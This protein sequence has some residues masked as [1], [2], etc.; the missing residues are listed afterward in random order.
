MDK[1]V[2]EYANKLSGSL[3]KIS[4]LPALSAGI[5][6]DAA[7]A[8]ALEGCHALNAHRVGIWRI[9]TAA[10]AAAGAAQQ[11][12]KN[13]SYYDM[14]AGE[15]SIHHDFYL[16]NSAAYMELLRSE[17]LIVVSDFKSPNP[18]TDVYG[19]TTHNICAMLDAPIRIGGKLVGTV[20]IEQDFCDGFPGKRKWM[21][22][23]QN[24]ASSLADFMAIAIEASERR[25]L[26]QRTESMMS[27]LPGMV[28]QCLHDPPDF[29]YTFVSE[30][31][32]ALTGYSPQELLGKSAVKYF[33]M[34]HPDDVKKVAQHNEQTLS[35]GLPL[36]TVFRIV[37]KDGAIKWVWERS[38]IAEFNPDGTPRLL[39][40]FYTDIT[41]QR[42]IEAA[43]L[44][45][46]AKSAFLANMSHEIRTPMNA[47]L[48]M[49]ELALRNNPKPAVR[50]NLNNIKT[51]GGQLLSIINDILDFSKIEAGAIEICEEKYDVSSMI[52]DIV[53]MIHV[54]IGEKPIEFI[55]DD[56][57]ELPAEMIGDVTRIKQIAINLLSNA[58]K[59][60]RKGHIIFS[61]SAEK[62]SFDK[63]GDTYRLKMSV[64]DTGMGIRDEDIPLLF[65]NFTQLDTR[66]NRSVEG[67]GLGLA[68]VKSL[69]EL[70]D[71]EINVTSKYNEGSCFSF[72]IMQKAAGS[73]GNDG[74][75]LPPQNVCHV[76]IFC[77]NRK[78]ELFLRDKLKK[79]NVACDI[80]D[81]FRGLEK[82]SHV[83]FDYKWVFSIQQLVT[84][85]TRLIA[86]TKKFVDSERLPAKA[87]LVHTPLTSIVMFKL[88]EKNNSR[89]DADM[90][91]MGAGLT[92]H[93]ARF[94]I[95]DDIDI[96]LI[97]AEETLAFY[98]G[99][100]DSAS[101]G[102]E[103]VDMVTK[104]DYDIVFMDHMMPG[105]DGIDATKM[106]RAMPE[107]KYKKLPIVAFTANVVGEAQDLLLE[108]GMSDFLSKPLEYA[109][110]E[111]VLRKWLPKHKW[112]TAQAPDP[113]EPGNGQ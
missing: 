85:E 67:T 64:T 54:R 46:R 25:T 72:H 17:R 100:V 39:E 47:I 48:G 21:I 43:A 1:N 77:E 57:P 7:K 29:T 40:G 2:F 11:V 73:T 105:V 22:E 52:N 5:L 94:L 102:L 36:D 89:Q 101:G 62:A 99:E 58:V 63:N 90:D 70:M 71:G 110:I 4:K 88:L 65:Q 76:A 6:E 59:F 81:T 106:I 19:H 95:V 93:N 103:A 112:S 83:I 15:S 34:I 61:I 20:I 78:K 92:L 45:N 111:R 35:M 37:M 53:T 13:I 60:T 23:E 109:Q 12:L 82:Y 69:I 97:I 31:S 44:A 32:L 9:D 107:A 38:R 66:K 10:P 33:D 108:S 98:N 26:L 74:Y 16:P 3:A 28:Y 55:V 113:A 86:L 42:R 87:Q 104:K 91:V 96:N 8:I 49:T 18:L 75:V 79:M 51:A 56:D 27:N 50:E 80:I 30:G 14:D 84:P 24:F 41:E 68:I